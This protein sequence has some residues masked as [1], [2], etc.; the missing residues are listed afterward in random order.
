[1]STSANRICAVGAAAPPAPA[2]SPRRLEL[3]DE[4]GQTLLEH[5][6][7]EVH[8]EVVVAQEVP[9]DAHTVSQAERGILGEVGHVDAEPGPIADRGSDFLAGVADDDADLADPGGRHVLD[10]VEQDRLVGD[11]DQLLG[12]GM[13]DRAQTSTR[14]AGEDEALHVA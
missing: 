6:V 3:G 9:G 1:M 11:R 5:V 13:G 14:A 12:L 4:L 2:S 7:A 10:P 8:D